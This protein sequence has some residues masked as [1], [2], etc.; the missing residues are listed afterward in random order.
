MKY[1]LRKVP[2]PETYADQLTTFIKLLGKRAKSIKDTIYECYKN[3]EKITADQRIEVSSYFPDKKTIPLEKAALFLAT[4]LYLAFKNECKSIKKENET[5]NFPI[6]EIYEPCDDFCGRDIEL[7]QLYELI[8]ETNIISLHG[9]TGIGKS[10]L[11]KC[12]AKK[13]YKSV[14]YISSSGNFKNDIIKM[15]F[16]KDKETDTAKEKYDNHLRYL[17]SLTAKH[18]L[19]ID[20]YNSRHYKEDFYSIAKKLKCKILVTTNTIFE[21][22]SMEVKRFREIKDLLSF[23]DFQYL[24]TEDTKIVEEIINKLEGHTFAVKLV[25]ALINNSLASPQLLLE[26]L[27]N[28]NLLNESSDKILINK[29][30]EIKLATY[31]QH[32][33]MLYQS[34]EFSDE[35]KH[36]LKNLCLFSKHVVP[37]EIF[38]N[39]M[40]LPDMSGV[41]ELIQMGLINKAQKSLYIHSLTSEYILTNFIPTISDCKT[42]LCNVLKQCQERF[43]YTKDIYLLFTMIE[44]CILSLNKDNIRF[45]LQFL[46]DVSRNIASYDY[47]PLKGIIRDE[48]ECLKNKNTFDSATYAEICLYLATNTNDIIEEETLLKEALKATY[49]ICIFDDTTKLLVSNIYQAYGALYFKKRDYLAAIEYCQIAINDNPIIDIKSYT[50]QIIM[51][52]YIHVVLNKFNVAMNILT[53]YTKII[54][55]K[56]GKDNIA[57]A[58]LIQFLGQL[59]LC[60]DKKDFAEKCL[61]ESFSIFSAE[62][63]KDSELLKNKINEIKDFYLQHSKFTDITYIENLL[64]TIGIAIMQS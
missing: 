14:I 63:S 44:N 32:I 7:K 28:N 26:K 24:S 10:E 35:H 27:L 47:C 16:A 25:A 12:F 51:Y 53:E 18:L 22:N 52:A 4:M 60:M 30:N 9:I 55:L 61:I 31:S 19:I 33:N 34:Y 37:V 3:D 58:S 48:I 40:E 38:Q 5:L 46:L 50:D 49:D 59:Y 6:V 15:T 8:N 43:D 17:Q 39:L 21:I 54:E 56:F 62:Y 1:Y 42:L 20:N 45:Y 23:F 2:N 57:Y 41:N 64:L 13:Y 29:D 36:I 11:A